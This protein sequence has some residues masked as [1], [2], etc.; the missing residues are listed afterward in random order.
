MQSQKI[1]IET[2]ITLESDDEI[3]VSIDAWY[4][5]GDPGDRITPPT[6]PEIEFY[7]V[8]FANYI[9]SESER[10]RLESEILAMIESESTL[11]ERLE[12][13]AA[14]AIA[15]EYDDAEERWAELQREARNAW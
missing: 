13:E 14:N 15:G 8:S 6:G 10:K 9:D 7:A 12:E 5:P 4:T 1:T 3:D 11:R 2:W